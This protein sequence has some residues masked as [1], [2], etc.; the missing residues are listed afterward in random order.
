VR[1]RRRNINPKAALAQASIEK[2]EMRCASP[3]AR[4]KLGS[5]D[6]VAA[7]A[8]MPTKPSEIARNAK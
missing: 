2:R 1:V 4:D 5:K 6:A 3:S 7:P 8:L